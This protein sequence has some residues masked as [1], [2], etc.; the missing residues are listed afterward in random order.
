M[1]QHRNQLYGAFPSRKTDPKIV[2][3]QSFEE[4]RSL[5]EK[6]LLQRKVERQNTLNFNGGTG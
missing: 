3:G 2:D 6:F 4:P 5:P 1:P